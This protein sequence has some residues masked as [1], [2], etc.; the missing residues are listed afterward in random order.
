MWLWISFFL[1]FISILSTTFIGLWFEMVDH[2]LI[3]WIIFRRVD[4]WV[5]VGRDHFTYYMYHR[6]LWLDGSSIHVS[7]SNYS[8]NQSIKFNSDLAFVNF[9]P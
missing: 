9:R 3:V 8:I 2:S 1:S 6:I 7:D 5:V 4:F